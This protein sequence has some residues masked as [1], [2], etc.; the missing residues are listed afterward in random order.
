[1]KFSVELE[2]IPLIALIIG[3]LALFLY[4]ITS[5]SGSLKTLAD[6]DRFRRV[7]S[8]ATSNRV[9][10]CAVGTGFTALIQSSGG[11][12]ALS[13]GLVKAGAL[14][15][16]NAIAI[17]IGANLGTCITS[18]L[19]A[20]PSISQFMPLVAFIAAF[21]MMVVHNR[22]AQQWSKI[23]FSFS[24]IFFGIWLM[25]FFIK[26]GVATQEW[27]INFMEFLNNYPWL[28][29]LFG[30]AVT[31]ILQSCS[32]V[33]GVI[34]GVF[35]A[36]AI[37]TGSPITL[38]GIL[39]IVIG[40]NIG[41][42]IPSIL[43]AIGGNAMA[44]RVAFVNGVMKVTAGLIFMGIL[45][46]MS[47]ILSKQYTAIDP[48]LQVALFHL[49]FNFTSVLLFLPLVTPLCLLSE[50]VIP[51]KKVVGEKIAF[52]ELD[53]QVIKTF[54]STGLALAGALSDKM[55]KYAL[56][57]FEKLGE[58]RKVNNDELRE[59]INELE[60]AIDHIDRHLA[61]FLLNAE[62]GNLSHTD[63]TRHGRIMRGIKDIER[64]GDYGE[65]LLNFYSNIYEKKNKF[66]KDQDKEIND[67]H[68][69]AI[70]LLKKTLDVYQF[71]D[72]KLALEVIQ[73][74]RDNN[75]KLE[76]YQE[77]YFKREAAK[78]GG[79]NNYIAL[80]YVDILNSYERV[81]SHC[82]NIA[83]LFNNDK[84]LNSYSKKDKTRFTSMSSRY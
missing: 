13:I 82:A 53:P 18:F 51:E 84:D 33:I 25:E 11:T 10:S 71:A 68:Q 76:E 8:R 4:G 6:G 12:Y 42:M 56:T 40:S 67:A 22:K 28:G 5:L 35:A 34:Q 77:A 74:R 43:S 70:A 29:L 62:T 15:Y 20:I 7:I 14:E 36:A 9:K 19:I 23:A 2:L 41:A 47:P 17:V 69:M 75:K 3:G 66:D 78:K 24:L 39:P 64:I 60:R 16:K 73:E 79:K 65:N 49:I 32:A 21:I 46:A 37:A 80:I 38:F 31:L 83:K 52:K 44:K 1:M 58:Y 27:F 50:K 57:M 26:N 45:Y 61:D 72:K 54:P 48:K 30:T 55:F 81:Y 63:L 59:Y